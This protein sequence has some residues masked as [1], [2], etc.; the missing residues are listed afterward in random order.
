MPHLDAGHVDQSTDDTFSCMATSTQFPSRPG[1]C[2]HVRVESFVEVIDDPWL[3]AMLS[4]FSCLRHTLWVTRRRRKK[5][6]V[7]QTF[8]LRKSHT[9]CRSFCGMCRRQVEHF[10]NIFVDVS[11]GRIHKSEGADV[12]MFMEEIKVLLL[13]F[14]CVRRVFIFIIFLFFC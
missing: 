14:T 7:K 4:V 13:F 2:M 12:R 8:P 3:A 5:K 11:I 6:T 1:K 10:G 9:L